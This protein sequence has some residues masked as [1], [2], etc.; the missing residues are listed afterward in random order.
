VL[1]AGPRRAEYDL[2]GAWFTF[3]PEG[4]TGCLP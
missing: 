2:C 1:A 4:L 3:S